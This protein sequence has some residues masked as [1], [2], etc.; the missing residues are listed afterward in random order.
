MFLCAKVVAIQQGEIECPSSNVEWNDSQIFSINFW[1]PKLIVGEVRK[2]KF[3]SFEMIW[4]NE[5]FMATL[6]HIEWNPKPGGLRIFVKDIC[7]ESSR[8]TAKTVMLFR[9]TRIN[10][11]NIYPKSRNFRGPLPGMHLSLSISLRIFCIF[12]NQILPSSG[13]AVSATV[14]C[15]LKW[16][17]R[18]SS[19][20]PCRA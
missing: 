3:E 13:P 12:P 20:Q 15:S 5:R 18:P 16:W 17:S 14:R 9:H 11:V 2:E 4:A 1:R 10:W 8:T 7:C 19:V 6:L